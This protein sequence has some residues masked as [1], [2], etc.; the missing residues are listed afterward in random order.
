MS[1]FNESDGQAQSTSGL[2]RT[3]SLGS[4]FIIQRLRARSLTGQILNIR[5]HQHY[6]YT[7]HATS[8]KLPTK[9]Q[10][11]NDL[12][13]IKRRFPTYASMDHFCT[14]LQTLE[15]LCTCIA[16]RWYDNSLLDKSQYCCLK[17]C[18][19]NEIYELTT[20]TE[21]RRHVEVYSNFDKCSCY[22]FTIKPE[23]HTL[24]WQVSDIPVNSP[25]P[26]QHPSNSNSCC[27]GCTESLE[28]SDAE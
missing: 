4:P 20:P 16:D 5:V 12:C 26:S 22:A 17:T 15:D 7:V 1:H 2:V 14:R 9:K 27:W 28:V 6:G 24:P 18:F 13:A 3:L 8:Y 21:L 25:P 11:Q 19:P 23:T 10:P